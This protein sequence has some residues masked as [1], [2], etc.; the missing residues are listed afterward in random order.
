MLATVAVVV[1][2]HNLAMGVFVGVLLSGVFFAFKVMRLMQVEKAYDEAG[3]T[4]TYRVKGQVFFASAEMFADAFDLR[5]AVARQVVIDLT[6]AH[7]WDITAVGALE[8]VVAGLRKR[9]VDVVIHGLNPTSTTLV[10]RH[11]EASLL[12]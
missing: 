6:G 2:T 12:A 11:A 9:G 8:G 1:V 4:R 5:D 7:L 10:E 3:R